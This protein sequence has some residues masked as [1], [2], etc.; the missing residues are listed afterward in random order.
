[1]ERITQAIGLGEPKDLMRQE[2]EFRSLREEPEFLRL[3]APD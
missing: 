3:T 1:L 2:V